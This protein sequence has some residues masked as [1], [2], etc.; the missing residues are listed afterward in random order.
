MDRGKIRSWE[1]EFSAMSN[2]GSLAWWSVGFSIHVTPILFLKTGH[3]SLSWQLPGTFPE[4]THKP[5]FSKGPY[6]RDWVP[7]GTFFT[8]W[9]PMG[10]LLYFKVPIFNVLAKLT[11]RMSTQSTSTQQWVNLICQWSFALGNGLHI[12][13]HWF[14]VTEEEPLTAELMVPEPKT[15]SCCSTI[16]E[17]TCQSKSRAREVRRVKWQVSQ[18]SSH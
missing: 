16:T 10:S 4:R 9:V 1:W 14:C 15:N 6:F 13:R 12:C 8:F 7:I 2:L 18:T 5:L 17:K 3:S 11:R